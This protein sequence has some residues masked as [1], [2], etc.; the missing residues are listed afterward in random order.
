MKQIQIFFTA[1]L[2]I[3]SGLQPVFGQTIRFELPA[4]KGKTLYLVASKGL[5]GD[6]ILSG[7]IDEKG[8]LVFTPSEDKPVPSCVLSLLIKPDI[9]FGLIYSPIENV[10]LHCEGDYINA[11]NTKI[12]N[13]PENDYIQARFPEQMQRREK[14]MFC[15]QGLQL[16]KE[17]KKLYNALKD[18]KG[19][20]QR[21]QTAFES[22]LQ[23]DS[24]KLYSARLLQLQN[25]MTN[26][27]SRLQNKP[28]STE[29]AGIKDY[30]LSHI[31]TETLYRSGDWVNAINGMLE[32]YYDGA[33]FFGQF[34]NDMATLLQRTESQ[35]VFLALANDAATI[36]SQFGWNTDEAALSKYLIQSGRVTNPQGKLKQ[37]LLL[38][39]LQPGL[40]APPIVDDSIKI[41]FAAANKT[42]VVFYESGCSN[43]E[44]ELRQL[45]GNYSVLKE[46]GIEVVSIA[47]DL[48][49]T[50]FV[51]VSLDFPWQAKLCNFKGF[52]GENFNNYGIIGT[53]TMYMIDNKGIILGKYARLVD[54]M[55]SL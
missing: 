55:P 39:K 36:C 54:L 41:D 19:A 42:L 38:N 31:N 17:N 53:P 25:L 5:Q 29:Q 35:E 44:N 40:P 21:Q 8:D 48:D 16:F 10:T 20:Q 34:G 23:A 3:G 52:G 13:S 33:P 18:E 49:T 45:I 22:K 9:K 2:F 30:V 50:V 27:I 7:Q 32:L 46:K 51:K 37:M 1:I 26:Y 47:S 4:Q 24:E 11:Q 28:D 43:C 12:L 15:E 14:L 6:T